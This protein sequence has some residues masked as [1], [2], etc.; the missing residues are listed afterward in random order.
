MSI[1]HRQCK[2]IFERE[3][4]EYKIV[5]IPHRQCKTKLLMLTSRKFIV[6]QF[7]IGNVKHL[8]ENS[9]RKKDGKESVNSS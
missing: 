4:H 3:V 2:T 9:R 6:C 5:S 8:Q 1:P 7:L